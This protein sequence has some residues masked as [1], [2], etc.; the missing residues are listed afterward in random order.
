MTLD[1]LPIGKA[2]T[3][4]SYQATTPAQISQFLALGI[5]PETSVKI[6]RIAPLGCPFQV[7]IG[8]SLISIR[9]SEAAHIV[10]KDFI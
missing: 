5:A 2:S 1:Q 4:Q 3:V 7:K 9:K 8:Q 6:L 10:V